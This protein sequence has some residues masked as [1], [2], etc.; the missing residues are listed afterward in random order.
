MEIKLYCLIIWLLEAYILVR[1]IKT[2]TNLNCVQSRE[3]THISPRR[4]G[5]V[6]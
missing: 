3:V 6:P 4:L 5:D 2:G 1:S